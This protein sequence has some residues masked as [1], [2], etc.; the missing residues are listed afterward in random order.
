MCAYVPAGLSLIASH[1]NNDTE[2]SVYLFNKGVSLG[3]FP[4]ILYNIVNLFVLI[5]VRPLGSLVSSP[6][7]PASIS[8]SVSGWW[9]SHVSLFPRVPVSA[10]KFHLS[11][12]ALPELVQLFIEATRRWWW[13]WET[14]RQVMLRHHNNTKVLPIPT[15][16][17]YRSQHLSNKRLS[18]HICLYVCTCVC[19][20]ITEDSLE[21]HC[22]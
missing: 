13:R 4:A 14:L 21:Y 22:S 12:P 15:L 1:P 20:H 10:R 19:V 6:S 8:S 18:K 7:I 17:K 3:H 11:T 5:S 16:C 2:T 9:I